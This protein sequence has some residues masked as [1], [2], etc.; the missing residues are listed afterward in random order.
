MAQRTATRNGDA[1][2]GS[3]A[4]VQ[5]VKG[6]VVDFD[7]TGG[8]VRGVHVE[9]GGERQLLAATHGCWRRTLQSEMA[10]MIGIDLPIRAERHFKVSFPET[11]G[12][13]PRTRRC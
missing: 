7:T 10:R 2:S 12:G 13:L 3:C 11:L 5:I 4:R 1:G 9:Q 6:R 8:R